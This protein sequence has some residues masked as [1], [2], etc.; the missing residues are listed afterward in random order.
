MKESDFIALDE[1]INY[2]TTLCQKLSRENRQLR[3]DEKSWRAEKAR[4]MEKNDVARN[5][6]DAMI[7]RLKSLEHE[8]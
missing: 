3:Q 7:Q 6:V 2:L 8:S 5:K 4:L 1:K